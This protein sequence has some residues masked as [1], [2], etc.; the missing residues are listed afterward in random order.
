LPDLPE[1]V[2]DQPAVCSSLAGKLYPDNVWDFQGA[3]QFDAAGA[4]RTLMAVV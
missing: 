2:P 1:V 3:E 4:W